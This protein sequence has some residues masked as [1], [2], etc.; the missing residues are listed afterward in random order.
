MVQWK[1]FVA[2][3]QVPVKGFSGLPMRTSQQSSVSAGHSCIIQR[4]G[5][6]SGTGQ[7]RSAPVSVIKA[8]SGALAF[9]PFEPRQVIRLPKMLKLMGAWSDYMK[10]GGLGTEAFVN[11]MVALFPRP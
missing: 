10:P 3:S 5:G 8:V 2:R 6:E 7:K 9:L 1:V 4:H 11:D